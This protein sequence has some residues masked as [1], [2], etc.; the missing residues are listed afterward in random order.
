ML[1][2]MA[3]LAASLVATGASLAQSPPRPVCVSD[4]YRQFD[5]WV[6]QWD[7]Y[8]PRTNAL[9]AHSLIEKLYEGCAVRENWMPLSGGG[10]G[11]LNSYRPDKK[12]W[13]QVWTDWQNSFNEYHGVLEDGA[14]VM[15]GKSTAPTGAESMTRMTF[16]PSKDGTVVQTGYVSPG[17]GRNWKLNYQFV[18][19]RS[20][21]VSGTGAR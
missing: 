7:V 10:G 13:V 12:E 8:D 21:A 4:E 1:K 20:P 15:T 9:V 14:M 18:Y 17:S 3:G 5:F 11:S 6:G 16:E 2:V 19:R